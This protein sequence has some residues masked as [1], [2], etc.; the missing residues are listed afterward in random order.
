MNVLHIT[1]R[2]KPHKESRD[3]ALLT[4]TSITTMISRP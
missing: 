1:L 3:I 4:V 2:Y